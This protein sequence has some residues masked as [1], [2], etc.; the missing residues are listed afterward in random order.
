MVS[1]TAVTNLGWVTGEGSPN[2]TGS[3]FGIYG[4][5]L[6]ICWVG[7][8]GAVM[9]AFGDT[10]GEGWG[11]NGAG[12]GDA[13]WRWNVL[14]TST[15]TDLDGGLVLDG[16]TARSDGK[17]A[18]ILPGQLLV[19][20]HTVIP[21]SG[22]AVGGRD[23]LHYMSVARWGGP[24]G[25]HTNHGGIAY[26]DDGGRNWKRPRDARWQN[27]RGGDHPLQLVAFTR[28]PADADHVY[29]LGTPNGR[30]G[31]IS[32]ARVRLDV[33]AD[34]GEYR[35]WDGSAW[36]DDPFAAR[37]VA[38]GPA[39]ELSVQYNA[40]LGCWTALHLDEHRAAIVLRTAG[41]LTGP[42]TGGEIV[43]SGREYPA[44]YG[45]F[46][47][48][49]GAGRPALYFLMSQWGPYNVMLLRADMAA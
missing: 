30:Y 20:E 24:H 28:H 7:A 11:G 4:T 16:V 14:A 34:P 8:S 46:L 35:Y 44:L 18:Q 37:P 39:G 29:L 6:G 23:Y 26:S 1:V 42:W 2:R 15:T 36:V 27:T 17:A 45:G 13:D 22:I 31:D 5:D 21:T 38:S 9:L 3:R 49:Y 47:H 33:V 10:Y 12:P 25:W 41:E 40:A 43:V 48:P 32:L 19:R